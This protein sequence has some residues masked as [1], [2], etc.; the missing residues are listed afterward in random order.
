MP[1]PIRPAPVPSKAGAGF[2]AGTVAAGVSA[3]TFESVRVA[4]ATPFGRREATIRMG[5]L[6][7]EMWGAG[8]TC[9]SPTPRG[10]SAM[11]LMPPRYLRAPLRRALPL[12]PVPSQ[13]PVPPAVP[14][15]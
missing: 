6:L 11:V 7:H 4:S 2:S 8:A 3:Y 14:G 1:R 12:G 5:A 15:P 10:R 13:M 9:A